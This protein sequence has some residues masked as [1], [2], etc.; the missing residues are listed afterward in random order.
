VTTLRALQDAGYLSPLSVHFAR[1]VAR[2]SGLAEG[3][4]A[5]LSAALLSERNQRGDVCLDLTALAGRAL[6]TSDS[7]AF[8]VIAPDLASWT[9]AL[10][11]CRCVALPG[12]RSPMI[13][14]EGRLYLHRYWRHEVAVASD[15]SARLA[16]KPEVNV[17]LLREGL[18]QLFPASA[19]GVEPDWQKLA[20]ALAVTQNFAVI[21]GGPGTGKTTTVVKVLSLLLAQ[22]PDLRIA[23]AAPTGKAAARM[24][25]SIRA[26]RRTL[27]LPAPMEK[28]LPDT[29]ST[30]HRLLAWQPDVGLYPYRHHRDNPLLIDCLVIDE[31]SMIDLPL[32]QAVLDALQAGTRL[33]LLGDRDQLASVE[34]GN[35]L[36]DITGHGRALVYSA[37]L[38]ESLRVL[39]VA[40]A[41]T[42]AH[43]A[44]VAPIQDAIAILRH[45]HRFANNS[46]I[47]RL[48]R[49]VNAGQAQAGLELLQQAPGLQGALP[50]DDLLWLQPSSSERAPLH[51][52][53]F[54]WAVGHYSQYLACK[55]VESALQRFAQCRVLCAAHEGPLGE[56]MFNRQLAERL[57]QRGL[58]ESRAFCHGTPVM[59]TVNDYE[60]ELYNGDIGLLWKAV[61]GTLDACFPLL[62]G[63]VRRIPAASLP[64][65]AVAWAMTVHKSQGS[66]FD[67]V[68]LVMPDDAES[69]L[70]LRELLYTG[71]T[72]ARRRLLLHTAAN[73]FV[74][75]CASPVTRS[76]GLAGRLGWPSAE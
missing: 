5:V 31:A 49:L 40:A 9:N 25:E 18:A 41:E 72:R 16:V 33:I 20:S 8:G 32:M 23:L 76:S 28:L 12:T 30:L 29:A 36:G 15:L 37:A 2:H 59:V 73:V 17:P 62:D 21:S 42:L 50:A 74:Q 55:D 11:D 6:F 56:E 39:G 68:L 34:A 69:P 61:D 22:K 4:L 1:F 67:E 43:A 51:H 14:D 7:G 24:V 75:A 38:V 64:A 45:S 13:L 57:Q 52:S 53:A 60:L 47:G 46:G 3:E 26:V 10:R 44:A 70:L 71:I 27:S 35:V 19:T 48:S 65:H 54:D 66:E 58:L 63:Q